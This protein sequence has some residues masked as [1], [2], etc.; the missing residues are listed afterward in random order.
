MLENSAMGPEQ[1]GENRHSSTSSSDSCGRP[2][3]L[4]SADT[5]SS[6]GPAARPGAAA[7]GQPE[8][9]PRHRDD[10]PQGDAEEA[11]E[12][13]SDGGG[14]GARG[15]AVPERRADPGASCDGLGPP[16]SAGEASP[17][18]R[19]VPH[20]A[21]AGEHPRGVDGAQSH[22]RAGPGA[23]GARAGEEGAGCGA[24]D[25][26]TRP[27]G[28]NA[29]REGGEEEDRG[30][31]LPR[32]GSIDDGDERGGLVRQGDGGRPG[33]AGA[34]S[35][36]RE[37]SHQRTSAWRSRTRSRGTQRNA[38]RRWRRPRST[39]SATGHSS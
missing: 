2:S 18:P 13:G 26:A 25:R 22:G 37:A 5:P 21:R 8:H 7:E 39:I 6:T 23:P 3:P 11:R 12:A 33:V 29:A 30:A 14:D 34:V 24:G 31:L 4:A 10:L 38:R 19:S 1:W 20:G 32:P 16:A 28:A 35:R 9:P 17:H 15:G 27:G 36:A